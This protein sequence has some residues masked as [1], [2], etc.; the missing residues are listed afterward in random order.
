MSKRATKALRQ[1]QRLYPAVRDILARE[2]DPIGVHGFGPDDEYDAYVP[3]VCGLLLNGA[4]AYKI[5][6][7]LHHWATHAMGLSHVDPD[8]SRRIAQRLRRLIDP[9]G[10]AGEC[11]RDEPQRPTL[12][13][14]IKR[15]ASW[16]AE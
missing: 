1:Y 12:D 2:W 14:S 11:M 5:A 7:R 3:S 13:T 16:R 9:D 15:A 6:S 8:H 10:Q 4:D